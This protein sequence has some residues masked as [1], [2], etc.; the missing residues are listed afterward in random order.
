MKW[1]WVILFG[2]WA[3]SLG[4]SPITVET[5][6]LKPHPGLFEPQV[7]EITAYGP[8][9]DIKLDPLPELPYLIEG[10]RFERFLKGDLWA[11][12]FT[13][14]L[15]ARQPGEVRLPALNLHYPTDLGEGLSQSMPQTYSVAAPATPPEIRPYAPPIPPQFEA[16]WIIGALS[17]CYLSLPLYF[18]WS[19]RG[20]RPIKASPLTPRAKAMNHLAE[21]EPLIEQDPAQFHFALSHCLKDYLSDQFLLPIQGQTTE[22]FLHQAQRVKT[23]S[24]TERDWF[25]AYLHLADQ[26][27][28]AQFEASQELSREA[29]AQVQGFIEAG[30]NHGI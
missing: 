21:I 13:F 15:W 7:W 11:Q 18:L 1:G 25:D 12:R 23:F 16:G 4:A 29:L 3:G 2:F 26:V 22:E 30:E 24:K 5:H 9:V 19:P 6:L 17:L 14:N 10:P 20:P 8:A 28:F 27:K